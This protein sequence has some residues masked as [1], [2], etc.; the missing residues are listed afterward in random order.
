MGYAVEACWE[1]PTVMPVIDPATD[2]PYSANQPE[3]YHLDLVINN[4]EPVNY[5][6]CCA[7]DPDDPCKDLRVEI[8]LWYGDPL[9]GAWGGYT[10][11]PQPDGSWGG[12]VQA[13]M[14]CTVSHLDCLFSWSVGVT[15]GNPN[16]AD[17]PYRAVAMFLH[18][19]PP[20]PNWKQERFCY[21]IFDWVIDLE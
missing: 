5:S 3:P 20:G 2:F 15:G 4:N 12:S 18:E 16:P 9:D 13:L 7:A 6:P 17:G 21:D 11:M 14:P 19:T 10:S 8:D 1:P